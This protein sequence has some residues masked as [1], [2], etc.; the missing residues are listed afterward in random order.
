MRSSK[1]PNPS[2]NVNPFYF[3]LKLMEITS[4]F[5]NFWNN[6]TGFY[7]DKLKE[8]PLLDKKKKKK[9]RLFSFFKVQSRK[10]K[11][12]VQIDTA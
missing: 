10:M 5:L 12:V 6:R 4:L 11:K 1:E 9:F 2:W 7:K 3:P 8:V